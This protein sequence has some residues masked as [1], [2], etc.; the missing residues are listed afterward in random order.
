MVYGSVARGDNRKD[1]DVD[2]GY[3]LRK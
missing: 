2:V 3:L 1:S